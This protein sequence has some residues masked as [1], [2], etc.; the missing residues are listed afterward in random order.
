[1]RNVFPHSADDIELLRRDATM[2]S[3][4]A[5]RLK[6]ALGRSSK[7]PAQTRAF[8]EEALSRYCTGDYHPVRVGDVFNGGQYTVL[9]KLGYGVYST[10]WLACD[11]K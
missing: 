6:S 1:V 5:S 7:Q 9:R 3:R 10:V 11:L 2:F 8:S 4:G